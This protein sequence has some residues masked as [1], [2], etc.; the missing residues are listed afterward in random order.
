MTRIQWALV[1]DDQQ[2]Q[3]GALGLGTV[4]MVAEHNVLREK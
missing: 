3:R 2:G 1:S 4:D